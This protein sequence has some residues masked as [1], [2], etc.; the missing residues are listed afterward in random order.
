MA[1]VG[2][3]VSGDS[4]YGASAVIAREL[5]LQRPALHAAVLGFDHPITGE[6]VHVTEPL[7]PDLVEA[8][9][10]LAD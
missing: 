4:A 7:P 3:P 2:H 8:H 5:G 10:R 1:A 9:R 6:A